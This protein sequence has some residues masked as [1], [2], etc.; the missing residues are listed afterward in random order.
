MNVIIDSC[1]WFSFLQNRSAD[2]HEE[3][4]RIYDYL[5]E[6]G[7]DLII[8][9]PSL[10][11]T[12]NTRLLKEG[13]R[14]LSRWLASQL[15]SNEH[16][17]KI[18]DNEYRDIAFNNTVSPFNDR[19]ISFVDNIIR[20]MLIDKST[21]IKALVTFNRRDFEDIC[22]ERDIEILDEKFGQDKN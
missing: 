19:G 6:I 2:H 18:P 15:V 17:I 12:L 16:Y 9:Y 8:P 7:V 3:A 20:A 10:Y 5:T 13:H 21:Q 11:E 4:V 14:E 1:F 22:Y